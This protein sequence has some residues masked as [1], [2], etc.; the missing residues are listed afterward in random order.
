MT[1][2]YITG[3]LV[4]TNSNCFMNHISKYTSILTIKFFSL[5]AKSFWIG[6]KKE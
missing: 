3:L 2:I 5:Y 6:S 4:R 1:V